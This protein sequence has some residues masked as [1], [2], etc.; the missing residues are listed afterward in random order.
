MMFQPFEFWIACLIFVLLMTLEQPKPFSKQPEPTQCSSHLHSFR[1][2]QRFR[3]PYAVVTKQWE[4][5]TNTTFLMEYEE[6]VERYYVQQ[7]QPQ[8]QT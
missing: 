2:T 1:Q 7:H 6:I 3:M 5:E 4:L 8:C